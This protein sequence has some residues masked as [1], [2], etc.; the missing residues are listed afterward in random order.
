[1]EQYSQETL[2]VL[3]FQNLEKNLGSLWLLLIFLLL[4][5]ITLINN[6]T[7]YKSIQYSTYITYNPACDYKH[8]QNNKKY[9]A[10]NARQGIGKIRW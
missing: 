10:N 3:G 8:W 6:Y 2:G 1:M 4:S 7:I 9:G 5:T